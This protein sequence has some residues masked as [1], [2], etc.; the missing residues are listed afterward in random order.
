MAITTLAQV[1]S[2]LQPPVQFVKANLNPTQTMLASQWI[3]SGFPPLGLYTGAGTGAPNGVTLTAP[4][5]GM[6]DWNDPATGNAY[7]ARF[8]ALNWNNSSGAGQARPFMLCDRLWHN[9]LDQTSSSLQSI[10][11]PTWPARDVNG[12]TTGE[13]V[14]LAVEVETAGSTNAPTISVAYT[15]TAN[16]AQ[17][18]VNIDPTTATSAVGQTFAIGLAPGSTGVKSVQSLTLSAG[19]V[20]AGNIHLAAFRP[21]CMIEQIVSMNST[22]VADAVTLGLP[23]LYNGSVLYLIGGRSQNTAPIAQV[24]GE[25]QYTFG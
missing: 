22:I 2:G 24:A 3:A 15:D 8:A 5:Q 11:S 19:W 1:R 18:S 21:I 6:F 25:L 20:G 9:G 23:L 7:L 16:N 17:T 13:G 14:F 10:T 4:Q 12:N